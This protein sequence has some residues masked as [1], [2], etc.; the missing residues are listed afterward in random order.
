MENS[1]SDIMP[2]AIVW[3]FYFVA[4]CTSLYNVYSL[5]ITESKMPI[6]QALLVASILIG[7]VCSIFMAAQIY[8]I[9]GSIIAN[10]PT[11]MAILWTTFHYYNAFVYNSLSVGIAVYKNWKLKHID[12]KKGFQRRAEDWL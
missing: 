2:H 1:V 7:S 3:L 4:F 6:K 9:K 10:D 11:T 5:S 12:S 8:W